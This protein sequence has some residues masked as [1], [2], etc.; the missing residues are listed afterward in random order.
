VEEE[1]DSIVK[2]EDITTI[3][4]PQTK[5]IKDIHSNT[6]NRINKPRIKAITTVLKHRHLHY[7]V[8]VLHLMDPT[9]HRHHYRRQ[10]IIT[11]R[12]WV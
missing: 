5:E 4:R 11:R 10:D 3:P 1:V 7:P 9:R 2:L 12:E 8:R 6:D